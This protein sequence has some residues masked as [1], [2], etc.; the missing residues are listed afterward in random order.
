ME[1]HN[2]YYEMQLFTDL[3]NKIKLV[4]EQ[5]EKSNV[6]PYLCTDTKGRVVTT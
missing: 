5:V 3:P 4:E 1:E 6:I 2:Q